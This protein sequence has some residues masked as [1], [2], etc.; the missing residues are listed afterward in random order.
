MQATRASKHRYRSAT[1]M[2]KTPRVFCVR[3]PDCLAK[4]SRGHNCDGRLFNEADVAESDVALAVGASNQEQPG[5]V[6]HFIGSSTG[7]TKH[8]RALTSPPP[9]Q[10]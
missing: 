4:A 9:L 5:A 7:K 6:Y 10:G 2:V 3:A 8:G 1:F